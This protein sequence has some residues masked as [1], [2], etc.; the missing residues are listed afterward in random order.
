MK[1]VGFW[2]V[3]RRRGE[4]DERFCY[5]TW[6]LGVLDWREEKEEEEEEKEE[7]KKKKKKE[8]EEEEE[9]EEDERI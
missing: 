4:E 3:R 8:E 2:G 1:G 5:V 9:E 7:E 6:G